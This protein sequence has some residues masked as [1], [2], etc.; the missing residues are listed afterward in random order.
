[1]GEFPRPANSDGMLDPEWWTESSESRFYQVAQD[2]LSSNDFA[3]RATP[4]TPIR[5]DAEE[6]MS[7]GSAASRGPVITGADAPTKTASL[8]N[9][10]SPGRFMASMRLDPKRLVSADGGQADLRGVHGD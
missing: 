1:M 2:C 8:G 5:P 6:Q 4:M 9:P 3:V 7:Y 10:S